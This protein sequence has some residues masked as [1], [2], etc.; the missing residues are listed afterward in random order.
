MTID[1][2]ATYQDEIVDL[3]MEFEY[4]DEDVR[5]DMVAYIATYYVE[6]G[7]DRFIDSSLEP[8]CR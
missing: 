5:L 7:K 6:S 1:E 4:L 2:L 8:T 3:I